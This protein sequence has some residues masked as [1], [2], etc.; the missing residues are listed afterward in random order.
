MFRLI[1]LRYPPEDVISA[2]NG[3]KSVNEHV[4]LNS[5]EFLDN[6]LEPSLKRTLVP[7]AENAIFEVIT[8]ETIDQLRVKVLDERG[9]LALL[10]QGRDP[11]LKMAVFRLIQELGNKEYIHLIQ[12]LTQSLNE[13]VK[14]QAEKVVEEL[15]GV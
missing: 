15:T 11:K 4:R 13:K 2:Y 10:L 14:R 7:I 9:C 8:S 5:V 1:G 12:P 3:I 6:L